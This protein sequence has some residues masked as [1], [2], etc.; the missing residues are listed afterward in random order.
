MVAQKDFEIVNDKLPYIDKVVEQKDVDG[1][2]IEMVKRQV[3]DDVVSQMLSDATIMFIHFHDDNITSDKEVKDIHR[4]KKKY[5]AK[6]Y[7]RSPIKFSFIGGKY[8]VTEI[9]DD[10]EPDG[11]ILVNKHSIWK[12][13]TDL[14]GTTSKGRDMVCAHLVKN[15][16]L[17][18]NGILNDNVWVYNVT[19]PKDQEQK[20]TI[21]TY[22]DQLECDEILKV[23][24]KCFPSM[25]KPQCTRLS[26]NEE[27]N[28]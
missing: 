23:A 2:H 10:T 15:H 1:V 9:D 7:F 22:N 21:K 12:N 16:L 20:V 3:T 25:F 14:K 8:V 27:E 28:V 24:H 6:Q 26:T 4:L 13:Q 18:Y 19:N 11:Y 17:R 5:S